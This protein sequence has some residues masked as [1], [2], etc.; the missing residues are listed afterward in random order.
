MWDA[1]EMLVELKV[2]GNRVLSSEMLWLLV[3]NQGK[4][5][6][7]SVRHSPRQYACLAVAAKPPVCT[8]L[9]T[10][11]TRHL[12]GEPSSLAGYIWRL[13]FDQSVI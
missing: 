6:D 1:F 8:V 4:R 2:L 11:T 9:M 3:T 10:Y 13:C 5:Q 12:L 7:V